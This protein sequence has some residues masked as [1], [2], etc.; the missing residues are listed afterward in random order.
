MGPFFHPEDALVA[1]AEA[2]L[3][4]RTFA[5]ARA[6]IPAFLPRPR[7]GGFAKLLRIILDQQISIQVADRMWQRLTDRIGEP[8]PQGLRDLDEDSLRACGFSRQKIRYSL[9]LADAVETGR[10]DFSALEAAPDPDAM[11]MLTALTGV[12]E[13][14]AECYLL[15]G[16]G[17]RDI[18]PAKDL[19]LQVAWQ[20]L[21][22]LDTRPSAEALRAQTAPLAPRRSAAAMVLW[23][24]YRALRAQP[25]A[26]PF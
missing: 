11:A 10:L 21:I 24:Y 3:G 22:G 19:A 9:G 15:F 16:M 25:S 14:T 20:K 18:M 17:R 2:L 5:P 7:G 13:W 23:T 1:D 6:L 4:D 12:G 8:T 26:T